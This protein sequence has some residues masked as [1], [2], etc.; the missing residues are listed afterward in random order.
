MTQ[1]DIVVVPL[2]ALHAFLL[3]RQV[4]Q[5]HTH[6]HADTLRGLEIEIVR[7]KILEVSL[8]QLGTVTS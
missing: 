1:G 3:S 4:S 5:T 6:T 8:T 2:I 7:L